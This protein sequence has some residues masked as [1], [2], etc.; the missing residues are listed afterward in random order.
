MDRTT[1]ENIETNS[2]GEYINSLVE[3]LPEARKRIYQM[4]C[5]QYL[6]NKEI[7]DRLSISE[8]TVETQLY[9]SLYFLKRRLARNKNLLLFLLFLYV[10]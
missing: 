9:R 1:E 8:K 6:S 5:N 10:K 7:A 3:Q 2:L 4:S